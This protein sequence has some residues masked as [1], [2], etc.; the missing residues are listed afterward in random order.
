LERIG[1]LDLLSALLDP[2]FA[3]PAVAS[4]FGSNPDWLTIQTPLNTRAIAALRLIVDSGEA[5]AI[6]LA[7]ERGCRIILDDRKARMVAR[8]LG[9]PVTGTVGLLLKAKQADVIPALLPLL[10]AL[11]AHHF[12]I[13]HALRTEALRLAGE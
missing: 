11:D 2:I 6:T 10:D 7:Q 8:Q 4:E 12:H 13:S 5:E 9:V 3:P 1:R